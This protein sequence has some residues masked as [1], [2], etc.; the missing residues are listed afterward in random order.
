MKKTFLIPLGIISLLLLVFVIGGTPFFLNILK[1]KVEAMLQNEI[2]TQV[3]IGSLKGNVFYALETDEVTIGEVI[4]LSRLKVSYNVLSLL[5][6]K[7]DIKGLFIDGLEV[8]INGVRELTKKL[9]IPKKEG[10]FQI[11]I[12]DLSIINTQLSSVFNR[13][14]VEFSLCM[15]G[16]LVTDLIT[17]DSLLIEA[18]ESSISLRGTF[19]TK[20][21]GEIDLHY[22]ASLKLHEFG[23]ESLAGSLQSE[24]YVRGKTRTPRIL[25]KAEFMIKYRGNVLFG[26]SQLSWKIPRLDSL[27]LSAD[28]VAETPPLQRTVSHRDRWE[29]LLSLQNTELSCDISSNH[30]KARLVGSL[31]GSIDN[32]DLDAHLTGK[33]RY[34]DFKPTAKSTIAY[35]NKRFSVKNF[36]LEANRFHMKSNAYLNTAEPQ[37]IDADILVECSD[38]DIINS[39]LTSPQ[40]VRGRLKLAAK[41]R[42]T[43]QNP[44]IKSTIEF[45]DIMAFSEDIKNAHFIISVKDSILALDSGII[46]SARGSVDLNGWFNLQD[47]T[48]HADISS[49]ELTLSSPEIFGEDTIPISGTITLGAHFEGRITN[50]RGEGTLLFK[51]FVYD[52]VMFDPYEIALTLKDTTLHLSFSDEKKSIALTAVTALYEPFTFNASLSLNHFDFRDYISTDTGYISAYATVRGE[53]DQPDRVMGNVEVES[54]SISQGQY[55][56]RNVS[57]VNIHISEEVAEI[58]P[59]TFAVQDQS[60]Q[61]QG[62]LP[63]DIEHGEIDLL[64]KTARIDLAALTALTPVTPEVKGFLFLD[65][66]AHGSMQNPSIDGEIRLEKIEYIMPDFA[67]DSVY[68]LITFKKDYISIEHLIGRINKGHLDIKGFARIKAQA[69]DTLFLDISLHKISVKSK[70]F[71]LVDISSTVQATARKDSVKIEGEITINKGLYNVPFRL[72]TIVEL[73]TKANRPPPEQSEIAKRIFCD[74]GISTPQGV[75]I[76]NNVADVPV[77]IDLQIRGYLSKLNVYGTIWTSRKGTISYLGKKFDIT[78]AVIQFD[79]PY[80]IDPV[81]DLQA[82]SPVSSIDGEYEIFMSLSGT[83][84]NWQLELTSNPPVPE[85]D[86]ISLLLIGRRRPGTYLLSDAQE[87]DLRGTAKDYAIGLVRGTIEQSAEKTLGFEKVEI[88]GDILDPKQLDIG[89]EKRIGGRFTLIYG[90]GIES[91]EFRRVGLNYDITDNVSIYTLHDQE[92]LNSSVDLDIH[93]KLR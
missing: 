85:Q 16:K 24:G 75:Q 37:R 83:I 22:S 8:D 30:G 44:F 66:A 92:N 10:P 70:D 80:K 47:S 31:T 45:H 72:Q 41:V 78:S 67:I 17:I 5:S 7:I 81:L 28:I 91:W 18:G 42:G 33:F 57:S 20:E 32:P 59:C 51:D 65:I 62:Q 9:K 73:L 53:L 1:S 68:S 93:F 60:I 74:I 52:T 50:P 61:V 23:I 2:D 76:A 64:C 38:I 48:F 55:S 77:D 6:K 69:I 25:D 56:M 19:P 11:H 35:K 13:K 63:L 40:P 90:T 21:Q 46:Q 84:N 87:I 54:F 88:T 12:E 36:T 79:D 34:A 3:S 29:V 15:R 26:S 89:I 86:I 82:S 58:N 39:F 4:H 43:I 27:N 71:G 49:D 14:E